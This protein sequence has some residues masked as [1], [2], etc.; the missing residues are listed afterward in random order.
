[1]NK[2]ST[3]Y[4]QQVFFATIF[5][6]LLSGSCSIWLSSQKILS[7]EQTRVFEIC[8]TTWNMGI[9]AVFGLLGSRAAHSTQEKE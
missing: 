8:N 4:F 6:T 5:L 7:T 2:K 1:M 3:S 9:G